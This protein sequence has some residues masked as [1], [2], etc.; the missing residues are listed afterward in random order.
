MSRHN[1]QWR[2]T[3]G[4]LA[5]VAG[6]VLAACGSSGDPAPSGSGSGSSGS[7]AL[8][9]IKIGTPLA[10]AEEVP[11]WLG[12]ANGVF[13][14][15]GLDV[16][17]AALG[18]GAIVT[19]ALASGSVDV[20]LDDA[21]TLLAAV[22]RNVP[23]ESVAQYSAAT[24]SEL[25]ANKAWAAARHLTS[26][27]PV[28]DIVHALVGARVGAASTVIT[29]H[30][31]V[32]LK[33]EGVDP[34]SVKQIAVSSSAAEQN[35][36]ISGQI[37]AFVAGPP[38]PNEMQAAGRGVILVDEGTESA[39]S[40]SGINLTLAANTTWARANA[41]TLSKLIS[42]I[43]EATADLLANP[44]SATAVAQQNLA[45]TSEKAL[46]FTYPLEAYSKCPT[47]DAAIWQ[48][49][50]QVGQLAGEVQPGTAATEGKVWTNQ[51]IKVKC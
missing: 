14:K 31:N 21:T 49:D 37:D 47:Q 33:S 39:W 12:E 11:I 10:N 41:G 48:K 24:P 18:S 32:L 42:A 26:R 17:T 50:I 16:T 3:I 34:R 45:G 22:K 19:S 36:L 44:T 2:L 27:S 5:V 40:D 46:L 4:V 6:S 1:S 8:T 7:S 25:I 38:L 29:G 43:H 20:A 35:L 28:S 30:E 9:T 15:Y 13:K 51:Y 23:I